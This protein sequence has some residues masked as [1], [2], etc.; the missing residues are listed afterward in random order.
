MGLRA[1]GAGVAVQH[2]DPIPLNMAHTCNPCLAGTMAMIRRDSLQLFLIKDCGSCMCALRSEKM[3]S[4]SAG[5][6]PF[7]RCREHLVGGLGEGPP[8]LLARRWMMRGWGGRQSQCDV[9][10]TLIFRRAFNY[11]STTRSL[12]CRQ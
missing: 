1:L 9:M 7:G 10:V 8:P 11:S 12:G 6:V 2:D 5:G 3:E 4:L